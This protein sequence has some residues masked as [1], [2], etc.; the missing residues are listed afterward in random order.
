MA[1][2]RSCIR[3]ECAVSVE[4]LFKHGG[5]AGARIV[6]LLRDFADEALAAVAQM[7]IDIGEL[8]RQLVRDL[9]EGRGRP[10]QSQGG[11][12]ARIVEPLRDMA[13]ESLAG[14]VEMGVDLAQALIE[15]LRQFGIGAPDARFERL[16][17]LIETAEDLLAMR[18][19]RADQIFA[20][21]RERE[22]DFFG[23]RTERIGDAVAGAIEIFGQAA[24]GAVKLA[25]K[26][27]LRAADRRAHPLAVGEHG[28]A[29]R[30]QFV[31]Q[32]ANP[33]LVFRIRA[34]EIGDLGTDQSFKFAGAGQ[35]PL[36][37]IAHRDDFAADGLRQGHH[38]LA[39]NRLGSRKPHCDLDHRAGGQTHLLRPS[40][41]QRRDDEENHRSECD[42]RKQRGFRTQGRSAG[43]E[44]LGAM[45]AEI[46]PGENEP[47]HRQDPGDDQRRRA[48]ALVQRPQHRAN[49]MAVVVRR[50]GRRLDWRLAGGEI[51][52]P[53]RLSELRLL[54]HEERM[55][56]DLRQA[57][58][59]T[60]VQTKRRRAER[61]SFRIAP[62]DLRRLIRV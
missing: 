43:H 58:Q 57:R 53:C 3:S 59:R 14:F 30:R 34:L 48:R 13:R 6:K 5:G 56:L 22:A 46:K 60:I 33:A 32:R 4:E 10:A 9:I 61:R 27:I 8:L 39:G 37:A 55:L 19:Q 62:H 17:R 2:K 54:R 51:A 23:L 20:R 18:G 44:N 11:A 7:R 35:G 52:L 16:A 40:R 47:D 36:D 21:L 12:L 49:G 25:G 15:A 1:A 24:G 42:D 29:L 28:L 31:D 38:L 45:R 50:R 41:Q 26:G